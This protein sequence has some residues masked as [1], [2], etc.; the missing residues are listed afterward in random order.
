[1]GISLSGF[2]RAF[3]YNNSLHVMFF[4]FFWL[5]SETTK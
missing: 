3:K 2:G 1:M 5:Y 4:V